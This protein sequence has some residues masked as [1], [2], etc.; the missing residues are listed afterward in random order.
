MTRASHTGITIGP[1]TADY[2][3]PVILPDLMMVG[4]A[5]RDMKYFIPKRI[6]PVKSGNRLAVERRYHQ[7]RPGHESAAHSLWKDTLYDSVS[8][9]YL[10]EI[11]R[12]PL[13]SVFYKDGRGA[14]RQVDGI[15]GKGA[16]QFPKDIEILADMLNALT[17]E[18]DL[19]LDGFAG[20][21]S[22]G[23]AVFSLNAMSETSR[24][25]ISGR[26]GPGNGSEQ[27]LPK[28]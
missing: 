16:F 28:D 6:N 18:G 19:I 13:Q 26:D 25:F 11:D 12:E 9:N 4:T 2:I 10:F 15:L 1:M 20:S 8:K 17:D 5:G 21:G 14:T 24:G 23:H 27:D 7:R 3:S 22:T